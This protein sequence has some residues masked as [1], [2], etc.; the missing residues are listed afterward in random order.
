MAAGIKELLSVL[1]CFCAHG[2]HD[3]NHS[4]S[5]KRSTGMWQQKQ[6]VYMK[7]GNG[8]STKNTEE[9]QIRSIWSEARRI[10]QVSWGTPC[11]ILIFLMVGPEKGQRYS[12]IHLMSWS[13]EPSMQLFQ[14]LFVCTHFFVLP[15]AA[16]WRASAK[17]KS[18]SA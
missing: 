16:S 12:G 8:Q 5:E 17:S 14:M 3:D 18:T 13:I 2:R 11:S 1:A 10:L 4:V 7:K 15:L 9:V 6:R